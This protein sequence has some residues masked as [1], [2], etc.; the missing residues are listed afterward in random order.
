MKILCCFLPLFVLSC[1]ENA[2]IDKQ[3]AMWCQQKCEG[4]Y[5][6][7]SYT[8]LDAKE[9]QIFKQFNN[10]PEHWGTLHIT[11]FATTPKD[12]TRFYTTPAD[13]IARH[14][15]KL[16]NQLLQKMRQLNPPAKYLSFQTIVSEY[17]SDYN[18]KQKYIIHKDGSA[19]FL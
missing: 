8:G 18:Y 4:Q 10:W 12:S 13:S 2:S 15:L 16:H 3:I 6:E 11:Y 1:A 17:D 14:A 9:E 19:K 5:L 7:V